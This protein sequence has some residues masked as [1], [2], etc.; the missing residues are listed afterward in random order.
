M[1]FFLMYCIGCSSWVVVLPL[2]NVKCK[3]DYSDQNDE[4]LRGHSVQMREES[5][6]LCAGTL[7][8]QKPLRTLNT[9]T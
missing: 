2:K 1:T 4:S 8:P 9:K 3:I 5:C 7:K 6:L